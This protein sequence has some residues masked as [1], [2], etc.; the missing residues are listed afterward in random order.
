MKKF[1]TRA[2]AILATVALL[3]TLGPI[4]RAVGQGVVRLSTFGISGSTGPT[5][6]TGIGWPCVVS[7]Y[8][9]LSSGVV[10]LNGATPVTVTNANLT[11]NSTVLFGLKTV[12]GTV[13]PNSPNVLTVTP[14][15]G[16]TVGGTASDTSVYNYVILN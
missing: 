3:G 14:G 4:Q 9:T 7:C 1:L 11:A 2:L 15:T 5:Q 16:F 10:T 8:F 13:S 6:V 12:G